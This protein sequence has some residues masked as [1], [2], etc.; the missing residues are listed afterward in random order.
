MKVRQT[1][2]KL[3]FIKLTKQWWSLP[4]SQKFTIGASENYWCWQSIIC[5]QWPKLNS[6]LIILTCS[7]FCFSPHMNL[8]LSASDSS[9]CILSVSNCVQCRR[10]VFPP[11][12]P[13]CKRCSGVLA[14]SWSLDCFWKP[15]I[16]S[17]RCFR[18][19]EDTE[20]R[21]WWCLD[22]NNSVASS[23]F[24]W[25]TRQYFISI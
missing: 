3:Q 12:T 9:L 20:A 25:S 6:P 2:C 19:I 4:L 14:L 18:I 16:Y 11:P 8:M 13:P 1:C 24:P 21:N 15:E 5:P 10:H 23:C 17:F 22:T 7:I